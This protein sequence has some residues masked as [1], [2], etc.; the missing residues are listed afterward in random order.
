MKQQA[1]YRCLSARVIDPSYILLRIKP[2]LYS[3][4]KPTFCLL[5]GFLIF[6]RREYSIYDD[7]E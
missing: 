4:L 1:G 2:T 5:L 6:Q 7:Q 3:Y